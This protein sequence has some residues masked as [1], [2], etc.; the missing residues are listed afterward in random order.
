MFKKKS[1]EE[2]RNVQL[3]NTPYDKRLK[4]LN[5]TRLEE[6]RNRGDQIQMFNISKEN[7]KT[8]AIKNPSI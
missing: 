8:N 1:K 7:D 6:I 5:I 3:K 2:L 4:I